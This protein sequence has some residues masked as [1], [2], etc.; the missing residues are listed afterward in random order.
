[1]IS[2]QF[3]NDS[4]LWVTLYVIL[5]F[6][7][8]YFPSKIFK[9]NYIL[10]SFT[11]LTAKYKHPENCPINDCKYYVEM[12]QIDQNVILFNILFKNNDYIQIGLSEHLENV[13]NID[14]KHYLL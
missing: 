8:C 9:K 7:K 14:Q 12:K 13:R 11:V 1:M 2:G 3:K 6:L 10:I 5:N 4:L